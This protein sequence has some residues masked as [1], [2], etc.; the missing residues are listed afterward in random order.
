MGELP[1][2]CVIGAGIS[3]LTAGKNLGDYGVPYECFESSDRIGGNWAFKNP[4]GRSSAYA[5]LHI[6]TSK[7]LL[8]FKDFPMPESYPDFPHH[9]E[10]KS[11][12]E[13]YADAFALKER[14]HFE[15]GVEHARRLPGGGWEVDT[16]DGETRRFDALVVA[17]GHHWD[18]RLP[19][20]PGTFTGE[21]IHSHHYISP[22]DPLDLRDKRVL[23]VGIGNS[24]ADIVSELSQKAWGN[25]VTIS[26][27]SGAWIIPKYV[28][29]RPVDK[30][31]STTPWLPLALQRRAARILP[32][33]ISGHPT[34]FGLPQP[35]HHFLEAH[36]TASSEL[37]L[38]LGSGDACA[39]PNVERLDGRTVHFVD[40]TSGEFDA[41]VYATGY[42]ISFPFFD[43]DLISAPGNRIDL[44]KRMLH[45]DHDDVVFVG[46]AQAVP[47]LFPFVECQ[48]RLAA[49]YLAGTYRPP[50]PE[51]MR[52][53]IAADDAR[54]TGH[55]KDSPRHT[56][57]M[58]YHVYEY[59][60]RKKE[61]PA[62]R[63]R[64]QRLGP[65]PLA[66]RAGEPVGV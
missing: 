24:A 35:N 44:Y 34:D 14:I 46:F 15:N 55:F 47:T 61:L 33:L 7:D 4:N 27:R 19:D 16:Q 10:I 1:T 59:E 50:A 62:G 29:G 20:F 13:L 26:T 56:Q 12:L 41:I 43:E 40:G 39:K 60:M 32:R 31:V 58:D 57:Q 6:D 64:A 36:P 45:P 2:T 18:A 8:S 23:V 65:V 42:N 66:G 63:E 37:L 21:T 22:T 49:R 53:V 28:F 30:V 51:E 54:N 17:N 9:S 48:S 25:R 52:R 38:R 3:G 11:Y 5:S